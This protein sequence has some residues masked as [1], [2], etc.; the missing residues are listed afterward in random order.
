[1][2][3]E[4]EE[5][6]CWYLDSLLV[7]ICSLSYKYAIHIRSHKKLSTLVCLRDPPLVPVV[8]A[9]YISR[10]H[11]LMQSSSLLYIE[12]LKAAGKIVSC[13]FSYEAKY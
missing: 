2:Y 13:M 7:S 8:L 11:S 4:V 6:K 12:F 1:M 3:L 10:L 9:M 5:R